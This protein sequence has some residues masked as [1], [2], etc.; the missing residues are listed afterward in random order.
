MEVEF[1]EGEQIH[2]E[3]SYKYDLSDIANLAAET[4]FTRGRTWL[5]SRNVSAVTC[6]WRFK[7]CSSAGASPPS[8]P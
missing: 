1:A 4:G 2:T 3:N 6:C 5:D 7:N 8:Q